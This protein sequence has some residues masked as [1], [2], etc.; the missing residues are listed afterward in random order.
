ML[1]IIA[2]MTTVTALA[3][4]IVALSLIPF[5]REV[6]KLKTSVRM[7]SETIEVDLKPLIKEL[8]TILSEV[9]VVTEA[10]ADNADGV[11][12]LLHEVGEV[13]HHI[14]SV[15][16]VLGVATEVVS[17]SSAWITGARVA[18]RFLADRLVRKKR[19]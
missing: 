4:V 16:R 12:L 6:K 18:G 13:G 7:V 19:G 3:L 8:H 17:V 5:L 15:N 11:K 9:K 14:H 2:I 1:T 10:A